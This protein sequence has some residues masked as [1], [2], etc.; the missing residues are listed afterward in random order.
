[1]L[2]TRRSPAD[3]LR[4][5]IARTALWWI[6]RLSFRGGSHFPVRPDGPH[7][8]LVKPYW[9]LH[10][11]GGM[12]DGVWYYD[13]QLD[14]WSLLRRGQF[15]MESQYLALEQPPVGNAAA[16]CFMVSDLPSLMTAAGP[17][18][19]RLAHLEAGIVAQRIHLAACALDVGCAGVGAFYDD[20]VRRFFDLDRSGWEPVYAVALGVPAPDA[21]PA[22]PAA[23]R[24]PPRPW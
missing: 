11:V 16:V 22:I 4:N 3:F 13:A 18:A 23:L 17:D 5:S 15:R 20:E 10:D 1:M 14:R 8:G 7:A 21:P 6:N 12:D 9:I 19:Y 24:K 2:L